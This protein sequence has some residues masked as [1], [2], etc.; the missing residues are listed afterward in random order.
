MLHNR[1]RTSSASLLQQTPVLKAP[2]EMHA[3]LVCRCV[4]CVCYLSLGPLRTMPL[5]AR[6]DA[7]SPVFVLV[8]SGVQATTRASIA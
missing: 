8:H 7:G 5:R 2:P 4:P 3:V 1:L 6:V